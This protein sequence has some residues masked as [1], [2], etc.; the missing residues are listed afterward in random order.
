LRKLSS[1]TGGKFY[2]ADQVAKLPTDF[3]QKPA[4]ALIHT[5][6]TF[7]SLINLKW[8]FFLLLTLVSGE[9]FLRKYLG[10]Y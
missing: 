3:Q 7:N 2:T 8:F 10:G 9:W 5:E 6:E 4:Q 1:A